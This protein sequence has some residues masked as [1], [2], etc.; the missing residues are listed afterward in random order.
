MKQK[1][2]FTILTDENFKAEVLQSLEPVLVEISAEWSGGCQIMTPI[3]EKVADKFERR[4]KIAKV[5]FNCQG[6]ILKEY[7]V[8]EL[9]VFLFFVNGCV[10]DLIV[11]AVSREILEASIN[12]VLNKHKE[13]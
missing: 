11:G 8:Y 10:V 5:D 3:L 7:S 2:Q 4:I 1:T 6:H 12:E 13:A 9:P